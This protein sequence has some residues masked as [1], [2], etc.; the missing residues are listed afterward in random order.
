VN[1][2]SKDVIVLGVI[3]GG[4]KKFDKIRK[5]ARIEPEELNQ[6]LEKLDERELIQIHE[7]KGFL[8]EKIEIFVSEKGD[9]ELNHRIHEIETDWNQM[10]ALYK[11]GD[12]QKLNQFMDDNRSVFPMMM[13]FGVMDIMMFSMMFNAIGAEM[14]DYVP[15][16][17]MPSD[18]GG[19]DYDDSGGMDDSDFDIG[20]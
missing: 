17:D 14:T 16:E 6:I 2:P 3:K 20:F 9:K 12:K 13:F 18:M 19:S 1:Y 5:Q 15:A 10:V 11:A 8:G 7:K 4:A